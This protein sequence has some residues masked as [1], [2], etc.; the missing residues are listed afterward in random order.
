MENPNQKIT[1]QVSPQWDWLMREIIESKM[2]FGE[3]KIIV[4]NGEPVQIIEVL[5]ARRFDQK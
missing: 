4:H 2:V 3:F 5:K 1:R